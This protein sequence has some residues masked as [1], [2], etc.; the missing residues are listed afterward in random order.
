MPAARNRT[1]RYSVAS[2]VVVAVAIGPPV[3]SAVA[4]PPTTQQVTVTAQTTFDGEENPGTFT[5]NIV[6]CESGS[7][8]DFHAHIVFTPTFG[9]FA[10]FKRFTCDQ[11]EDNGFLLRL[12]ARF[13]EVGST[14]VWSAVHAFGSLKRMQGTGKLVA[15]RFPDGTGTT[16]TYTGTLRF[17][18]NNREPNR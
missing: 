8:V 7:V 3:E 10:G 12:N 11:S 15:V 17:V 4:A 1:L 2:L 16:D 14:G 9:V 18:D 13:D 6:G 5:S